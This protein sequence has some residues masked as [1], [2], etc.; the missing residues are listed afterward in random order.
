MIETTQI[1]KDNG[2]ELMSERYIV[3]ADILSKD[4]AWLHRDYPKGE[5]VTQ[6]H[7]PTYGVISPRGIAVLEKDGT[8]VELPRDRLEHFTE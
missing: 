6:Y 1:T 7:G 5:I 3:T 8:F 4:F 2:E